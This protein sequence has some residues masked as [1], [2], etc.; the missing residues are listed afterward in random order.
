MLG[1]ARVRGG[2]GFLEV[3]G[4]RDSRKIASELQTVDPAAR[5]RWLVASSIPSQSQKFC[6]M[7]AVDERVVT[8]LVLFGVAQ[9]DDPTVKDPRLIWPVKLHLGLSTKAAAGLPGQNFCAPKA[10]PSFP[11]WRGRVRTVVTPRRAGDGRNKGRNLVWCPGACLEEGAA[12]AGG[13]GDAPG[14]L[15][16]WDAVPLLEVLDHG[17]QFAVGG[18]GQDEQ[19]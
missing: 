5:S 8:S 17:S 15:V 4:V 16:A 14:K 12:L 10:V 7:A 1:A 2:N 19:E 11:F 6:V 13:N 9:A 18:G 3:T